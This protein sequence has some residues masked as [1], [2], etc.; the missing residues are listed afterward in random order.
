MEF[1]HSNL[2]LVGGHCIG[3]DPYYLVYKASELGIHTEVIN[4]EEKL[5][6][7]CLIMYRTKL[8][9]NLQKNLKFR[10][11]KI[12][13]LGLTFKENV[14]DIRNSKMIEVYKYLKSY[15]INI[16]AYDPYINKKDIYRS[17]KIKLYEWNE[18]PNESDAIIYGVSHK[19]LK[20]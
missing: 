20:D 6:T 3:V 14:S 17:H 5:M 8:L 1:Q 9:M 10:E 19:Q 13:I 15:N 18:L 12:I 2:G 16:F 4:L 7:E 11:S